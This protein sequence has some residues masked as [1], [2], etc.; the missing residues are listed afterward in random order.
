MQTGVCRSNIPKFKVPNSIVK[1][2]G[3]V[4]MAWT[5]ID[6]A[7]DIVTGDKRQL[8]KDVIGFATGIAIGAIIGAMG[9]TGGLAIVAGAIISAYVGEQ[10]DKKIDNYFDKNKR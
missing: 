1:V 10:I 4:T 3:A 2:G 9:C 6:I 8:A 5:G 7:K